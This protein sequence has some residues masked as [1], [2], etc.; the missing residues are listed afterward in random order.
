MKG[1]I[2]LHRKLLDHTLFHSDK[3]LKI[4]I[5]CL[6]KA[7]HKDN[8]A[9]MGR[10][11]VL[12]K[13][14]QFITGS[15]SAQDELHFAISTFWHWINFLEKEGLIETKRNNKYTV[16]TVVEWST[17]QTDLKP[18][19]KQISKQKE[20]KSVTNKN[21]KNVKNKNTNVFLLAKP[22]EEDKSNEIIKIFY[23]RINP[24]I[25]FGSKHNRDGAAWLIEKHGLEKAKEITEMACSIQG[26][27]Y[28]P[29]ITTPSQLKKKFPQLAIYVKKQQG[30][31]AMPKV[32]KI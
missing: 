11:K 13:E 29:V 19:K 14:G 1:W 3:C 20:N 5:W 10:N 16:I 25:S 17:Y 27:D 2:K 9:I 30:K 26:E 6:L 12:V 15:F 32:I 28:A 7:N 4:W 31:D 8:E 23:N 24:G 22:G 18:K 21:V